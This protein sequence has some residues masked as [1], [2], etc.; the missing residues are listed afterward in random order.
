MRFPNTQPVVY[1]KQQQSFQIATKTAFSVQ[2]NST[3]ACV[4]YQYETSVNDDT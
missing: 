3:Y 2:L 1:F 4:I